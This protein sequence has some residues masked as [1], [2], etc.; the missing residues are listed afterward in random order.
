MSEKYA[1]FGVEANIGEGPKGRFA[2]W[3]LG[4][5]DT[6][7]GQ[8]VRITSITNESK[9]EPGNFASLAAAVKR[10]QDSA[11]GEDGRYL[12]RGYVNAIARRSVKD[13][14]HSGLEM[15]VNGIVSG[16]AGKWEVTRSTK[17]ASA[18]K[19]NKQY[20]GYELASEVALLA[21]KQAYIY[22]NSQGWEPASRQSESTAET[23]DESSELV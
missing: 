7:D 16:L 12:M 18:S 19:E 14:T 17:V 21:V 15:T 3:D 2:V 1:S 6:G 13:N 22:L 23:V 4:T 11:N 20:A 10:L 5:F 8:P 9:K